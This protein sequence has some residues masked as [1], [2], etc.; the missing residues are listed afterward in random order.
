ML[1]PSLSPLSTVLDLLFTLARQR[2]FISKLEQTKAEQ[3]RPFLE[4][5]EGGSN[6]GILRDA[7]VITRGKKGQLCTVSSIQRVR[8]AA[9]RGRWPSRSRCVD[10]R[11]E[12]PPKADCRRRRRKC[13]NNQRHS[14]GTLI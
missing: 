14:A 1:F 12:G 5:Y 3:N 10:V 6:N 9:G 4:A 2:A 13:E 8:L 7:R 11:Q